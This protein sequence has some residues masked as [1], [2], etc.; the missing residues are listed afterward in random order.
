[1]PPVGTIYFGAHVSPDGTTSPTIVAAFESQIGRKLA[2]D[3]HYRGWKQSFPTVD[4]LDD[5]ANGRVPV[6]SWSCGASDA[7]VSSG[8]QDVLI[9]ERAAAIKSY[10]RPLFLR[11]LW[12]MNFSATSNGRSLCYDPKTDLPNG[13]FSPTYFIAAWNHIRARFA[14]AGVTNVIWLWNPGSGGHNSLQYYP[15][16][17]AVDWVGLDDYDYTSEPFSSLL[18]PMYSQLAPLAKPLLIAET[19]APAADQVSFLD[20]VVPALQSSFP[21]VAGFMYF[22]G[23]RPSYSWQLTPAG[24]TAAKALGANPYMSA[25]A[26]VP[27]PTPTATPKP[28]P[29]TPPA[30]HAYFGARVD[31]TQVWSEAGVE[32]FEATIGRRLAIDHHYY[33]W[34]KVATPG[35]SWPNET[36]D[37]TFGRIPLVNFNCKYR[38]IDIINGKNDSDIIAI[39]NNVKAFGK[40]IMLDYFWEMNVNGGSN[41]RKNCYDPTRDGVKG[42]VP[43]GFFN[44]SDFAAAWRHI[45]D[46]FQ[47][48]DVK[49]AVWVFNFDG[50]G[51]QAPGPYYPGDGFVDWIGYDA[52]ARTI[53]E[54][55]LITNERGYN[56]AIGVSSTKPIVVCETGV[57]ASDDQAAWESGVDTQIQSTFPNVRAWVYWDSLAP[58]HNDYVLA[59]TGL[60]QFATL[61]KTALFDF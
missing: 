18:A 46:I 11:F 29:L 57:Q 9:D 19:A 23:S 52:Y 36:A 59:G 44:P 35:F 40:P 53:G 38:D 25:F 42:G 30:G 47:Q 41:S 39:A 20:G 8:S 12:E 28:A 43:D 6:D 32:S 2:L 4:E 15:G 16:A 60:T 27:T 45:H 24:T 31:P 5:A 55:F 48:Q 17:S 37:E 3:L 21:S 34:K 22:D 13:Y 14:A 33:R 54:S 26:A 56:R 1:M 61:G 10:G 7:Q 58:E 50:T 51:G 49:N